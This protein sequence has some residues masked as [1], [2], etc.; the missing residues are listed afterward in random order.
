MNFDVNYLAILVS[1]IVFM[2]IGFLWYGPFFSKPWMRLVGMSPDAMKTGENR[3]RARPLIIV[4]ICA[5]ITSFVLAVL[6]KSL[7]ITTANI[8]TAVELAIIV[9]LG[10]V[11][12][13][14]LYRVLFERSS[15]KLWLINAS[16]S[17][18][19]FIIGTLILV[20]WPW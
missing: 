10:F 4:F 17:L 7:L 9:W 2:I 14:M 3:M 12:T 15:L 19:A 13:T 1:A 16:Q 6:L 20:M 11:A 5:L 18:V 8:G